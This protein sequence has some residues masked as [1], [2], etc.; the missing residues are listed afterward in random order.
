MATSALP[1]TRQFLTSLLN[2]LTTPHEPS[3]RPVQVSES[4]T[5]PSDQLGNPLKTLPPAQ[6]ALL[7]TLHVLFP[8]PML[9]QALDL[10]DRGLVIRI[11]E[12][13]SSSR[14]NNNSDTEGA[15]IGLRGPR[16]SL[17][18][19][20]ARTHL[21]P[22]LAA[23]IS[24]TLP[25]H[26]VRT[27][28]QGEERTKQRKTN[29]IYQVR[30]SQAPKSRFSTS[31]SGGVTAG[32]GTIYTVRLE[33]WNCSCAAFAFSAFPGYGSS[34]SPWKLP[35]DDHDRA[36]TKIEREEGVWEFGGL[37]LNE[38]SVPV[39]KHLLACLLGERWSVLGRYVK[40]REVGTEEM[41]GL[42]GEG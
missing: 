11:I 30:S 20:Q 2:T 42:G 24:S 18:P 27:E 33:A 17:Q 12:T 25:E 15:E 3:A 41:A 13:S 34:Q 4:Y 39:C 5:G 38:E 21:R 6:K 35:L 37:S 26:T 14:K 29:Q 32:P 19:L 1:T 28:R 8:P 7:S 16:G 36:E 40:K 23:A 9:L 31:A 22:D 10:L